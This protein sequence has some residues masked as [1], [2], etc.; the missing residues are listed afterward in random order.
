VAEAKKKPLLSRP[1]WVDRIQRVGFID[2]FEK[3]RRRMVHDE[4]GLPFEP[5]RTR[6]AYTIESLAFETRGTLRLALNVFFPFCALLFL[7]SFFWDFHEIIRSCSVAGIIGFSTNWVAIK[8]LFWPRQS[9]PIFGHGLIPSQRDQ[10]IDKVA[11]EVLEKLINEELILRKIDETHLVSRFSRAI[12]DK[13]YTLVSDPE[14]K[15][16]L[17]NMVLTYVGELTSNQEFRDAMARRAEESLEEF[18]GSSFRSWLV[19]RLKEVW[20]APL[21]EVLNHQIQNLEGTVD[22]GLTEVDGVLER[23]PNALEARQEA[24]DRVMTTMLVGLVREVD[25]RAIVFEQLSTVTPE[26][27]EQGFR[28]F[29]DDKLSFITLLGGVLGLVGGTIIVWPLPSIA[30]LIV[31]GVV[32]TV[33]DVLIHPLMQSKYWPKKRH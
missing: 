22:E 4:T 15:A 6:S 30:A 23:L 27:L 19:R 20:R 16:D 25:V 21:I 26:Q 10:L 14:F 29:S 13:L 31:I 33:L 2:L 5:T 24:I 18:A 7:I 3:Y 9:R 1:H 17:R 28:E 11:S 32:L 12:I 8:M